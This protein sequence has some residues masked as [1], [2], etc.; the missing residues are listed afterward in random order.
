M[1]QPSTRDERP[2]VRT[3]PRAGVSWLDYHTVTLSAVVVLIGLVRLRL[4]ATPFERDEGE[5]TYMGHLILHG[6]LPYRDAYN[7]KLPGTYAVY[8]LI[9]GVFGS[10]PTGVHAGF[11][12]LSLATIVLAYAVFKRLF[13]PGVGLVAATT[14]GLLSVSAP[15]L[16]TAAH[17]THFVN[18][19]VL[20]GLWF[21]A[22][23][24]DRRPWLHAGLAGLMFGLA[25]LMKQPAVFLVAFGG[26]MVMVRAGAV[27]PRSWK[28]IAAA[29]TA[30]GVA[31]VLPYAVVVLVMAAGGAFD[32]FWFW[33]VTYAMSYASAE[34]PRKLG[35]APFGLSFGPMFREYPVVWVL[36]LAGLP[37]VWIAR[38]EW[39]QKFL[40]TGLAVASAAAVLPGL[41][42]RPHYFVV[43]LPA[44]G[45]LVAV[46]LESA[47]RLIPFYRRRPLVRA[48]PFIAIAAMGIVAIANGRAYYLDDPPDEVSRK[49]YAGN[50]FVEAREVGAR[51]ASDTTP[52]DTVAVVGSEP[53]IYVYSGRRAA[54]GYMY[55][56][57]LTELQPDNVRMQHEMMAEI[58]AARPKYLVVLQPP[59]VV[60]RQAGIAQ[61]HP[62]LAESVRAGELRARGTGG[63]RHERDAAGLRLGRRGQAHAH[64]PELALGAAQ[65]RRV[66]GS[67]QG[68]GNHTVSRQRITEGG[69][70][71]ASLAADLR[72]VPILQIAQGFSPA[73][74]A[75]YRSRF[76]NLQYAAAMSTAAT[77]RSTP[78]SRAV[79]AVPLATSK[80]G[81]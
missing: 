71:P 68:L 35:T 48:M 54:T 45:L 60:G 59:V 30:F 76:S 79:A 77:A 4:L 36:T 44:V 31:A 28:T 42:F 55:T 39:R 20:L 70:G 38:Y 40:A 64:A 14:Y 62:G 37:V 78:T 26:L 34:T 74:R 51:I 8:S 18:L 29:A 13:T 27:T 80:P 11:A 1:R 61:G 41:N 15:M 67:R 52:A 53:E 73:P 47:A 10:S 66:I 50:P 72:F 81:K 69:R 5:Y 23:W 49:R 17:A 22:R 33:T 3:G 58:E 56:Y 43:L 24:D 16:G 65:K 46:A 2:A 9:E 21:Y 25:F 12:I 63:S 6:G 32:K 57:P 7:M 19:F 75:G